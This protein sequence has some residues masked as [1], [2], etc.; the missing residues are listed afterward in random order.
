M[1]RLSEILNSSLPQ[2]FNAYVKL[3]KAWKE[4]AGDAISF[5]TTP[6]NLK[7]GV[8]SVAVHD[9]AWLSEIGFLKGEMI[10]RLNESGIQVSNITFFYKQRRS[11]AAR[12]DPTP[13][14]KMTD[15]EKKF[16]D[17]LVDTISDEALRSSFR[18]AIYAYFTR[19]TLDDYLNC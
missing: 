9:Q 15:K 6:G 7:E 18:K 3:A 10:A 5:L 2:N 16:A 8:L 14:K 19:Y 13:R 17:R 11:D 12:H 4:C 1:K